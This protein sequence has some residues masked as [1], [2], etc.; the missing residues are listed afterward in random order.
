M[1]ANRLLTEQSK[2]ELSGSVGSDVS[3]SGHNYGVSDTCRWIQR[4]VEEGGEERFS[5]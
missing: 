2:L 1:Y 3:R 4:E 5:S